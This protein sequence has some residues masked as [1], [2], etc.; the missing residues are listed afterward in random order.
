[1]FTLVKDLK[2]KWAIRLKDVDLILKCIP[3]KA[4]VSCL[5]CEKEILLKSRDSGKIGPRN[6]HMS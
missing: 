1:M 6:K 5:A 3:V 2:S 4:M